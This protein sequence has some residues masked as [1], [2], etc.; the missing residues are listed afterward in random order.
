MNAKKAF[1]NGVALFGNSFCP[2]N[3]RKKACVL[4][5]WPRRNYQKSE[6]SLTFLRFLFSPPKST[7]YIPGSFSGQKET[8][9]QYLKYFEP[10]ITCAYRNKKILYIR[11]SDSPI[12]QDF[13]TLMKCELSFFSFFC[14]KK[15]NSRFYNFYCNGY[16]VSVKT[17]FWQFFGGFF[18]FRCRG[19]T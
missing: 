13:S 2:E 19:A 11:Y 9:N 5:H 16:V 17:T 8:T 4:C 15:Q 1:F 7:N 3:A 14:K 18:F 12:V 10:K 6:L